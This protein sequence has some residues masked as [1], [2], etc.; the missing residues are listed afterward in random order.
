MYGTELGW[1]L[2]LAIALAAFAL[3]GGF[4]ILFHWMGLL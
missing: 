4:V 1:K 2:R 3:V